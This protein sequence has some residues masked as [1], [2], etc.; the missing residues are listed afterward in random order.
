M[1]VLPDAFPSFES[2]SLRSVKHKER[3][4]GQRKHAGETE[5]QRTKLRILAMGGRICP[6]RCVEE[7]Y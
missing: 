5:K 4:K 6:T 2:G 3:K 1:D 7:P